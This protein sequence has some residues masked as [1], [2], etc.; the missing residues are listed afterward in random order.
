M[1]LDV[2]EADFARDGIYT[3]AVRPVDPHGVDVSLIV[4]LLQ[5]DDPRRRSYL[6]RRWQA[7]RASGSLTCEVQVCN[8]ERLPLS[9]FV[10]SRR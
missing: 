2:L 9:S 5:R 10:L 6:R 3:T 1:P 8:L 7:H 4:K